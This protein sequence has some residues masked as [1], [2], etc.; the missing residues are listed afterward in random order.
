MSRSRQSARIKGLGGGR[1]HGAPVGG[2]VDSVWGLSQPTEEELAAK[3][4]AIA[5]RNKEIANKFV[6]NTQ[7]SNPTIFEDVDASDTEY[8]DASKHPPRTRP[9]GK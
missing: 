9:K 2:A 6:N 8:S 7:G 3:K 1:G 5:K 4:A